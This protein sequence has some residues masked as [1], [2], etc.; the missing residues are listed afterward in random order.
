[1]RW[2]VT[3]IAGT[4]IV[5]LG[6][7]GTALEAAAAGLEAARAAY[8]DVAREAWLV[9]TRHDHDLRVNVYGWRWC[10]GAL[11]ED[12]SRREHRVQ[13]FRKSGRRR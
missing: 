4:Q 12:L 11:V 5:E 1:M 2:A 8:P 9:L 3:A 13:N 7:T 10:N 6:V